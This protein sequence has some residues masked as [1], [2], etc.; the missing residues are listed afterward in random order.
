M[1]VHIYIY[2]LCICVC[3]M[4]IHIHMCVRGFIPFPV[5]VH[6]SLNHGKLPP[7]GLEKATL[8][9]QGL[10]KVDGLPKPTVHR[11]LPVA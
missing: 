2:V 10:G 9:T 7:S 1:Y 4:H 6:S 3:G 8:Q 5:R 11:L